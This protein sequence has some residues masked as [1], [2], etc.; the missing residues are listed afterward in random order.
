MLLPFSNQ[1]TA[2][3]AISTTLYNSPP[4]WAVSQNHT[5]DRHL[6]VPS[7]KKPPKGVRFSDFICTFA[8][9]FR[10]LF[11]F[12]CNTKTSNVSGMAS[13]EQHIVAPALIKKFQ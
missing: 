3:A 6:I 7:S 11:V 10:V 1:P 13:P 9:P 2:R 8:I 5:L 4:Q 12:Y